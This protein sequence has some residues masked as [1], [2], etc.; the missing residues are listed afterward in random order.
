[1]ALLK[2]FKDFCDLAYREYGDESRDLQVL[3]DGLGITQDQ[4]VMYINWTAGMT[5]EAI[6]E[7]FELTQ[8]D[9]SRQLSKLEGV[10]PHLFNFKE[11]EKILQYRPKD[12]DHIAVHK[13]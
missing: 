11:P 7:E 8:C 12:H 4:V 10:F 3:L 6:A 13:F 5:Q 9:V 1:M 2:T